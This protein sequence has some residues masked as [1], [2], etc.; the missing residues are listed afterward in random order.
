[1]SQST[2]P[3]AASLE[4]DSEGPASHVRSNVIPFPPRPR[5]LAHAFYCSHEHDPLATPEL[6]PHANAICEF[7]R[8]I[9]TA[10]VGRDSIHLADE[11]SEEEHTRVY[12]EVLDMLCK[13]TP[14]FEKGVRTLLERGALFSV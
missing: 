4:I 9:A 10:V 7:A 5:L 12:A 1:M 13:M 6:E 2:F 3:A 8:S 14:D 11:A